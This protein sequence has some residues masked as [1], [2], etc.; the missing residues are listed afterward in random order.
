MNDRAPAQSPVLVQLSLVNAVAVRFKAFGGV[1]H[2][3]YDCPPAC[4]SPDGAMIVNHEGGAE[5]GISDL[6]APM[7]SLVGVFLGDDRPDRSRAPKPLILPSAGRDILT[8][9]PQLQQ[10]F[11]I[12]AG[13]TKKGASRRFLVP[14]DATRLFL[15]TMDGFDW[16]NNQG[17]FTVTAAIERSETSSNMFSVD[18]RIAYA[19]WSCLPDRTQCTPDRPVVKELGPGQYHIVLPAQFEWG[20][21]IPTPTGTTVMFQG[22]A[23]TVCLDSQARSAGKCNGPL[24]AGARAGAGFLVPEGGVGALIRKTVGDRTYF[25]VNDRSGASFQNHEGYFEF[26]A[27]VK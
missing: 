23:G 8:L 4:D 22:A 7:N 12:G 11:F 19:E 3:P 20:A 10:L 14:K 13:F 5:H 27:A 15:G 9:S 24:G 16:N 26:N 18:S 2:G 21:S 25:S 17:S 6:Y 1:D